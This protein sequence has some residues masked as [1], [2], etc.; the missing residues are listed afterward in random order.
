MET[1]IRQLRRQRHWTLQALADRVGTTP[2]TVQ[3]LETANMTVSTDWLERF[4]EA[5][6]VHPA[7][8]IAGGWNQEISML[9]SFGKHGM[10]RLES[11]EFREEDTL[12]LDIPAD[13]PVGFKLD[14]DYGP[15]RADTILVANR[16]RGRDME[17]VVGFDGFAALES[18]SVLLRRLIRGAGGTHTLVPLQPG[19]DVRY[20]QHLSWAGS[21]IM[22]INYL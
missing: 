18:G 17:N 9:G 8:L 21:L 6:G 15:Y 19:E 3:R 20:D 22:S 14:Q 4:A 7:D 16:L 11:A 13:D 5:F 2:Q 12:A 1:R 10:L